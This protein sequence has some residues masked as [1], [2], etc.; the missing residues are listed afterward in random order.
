MSLPHARYLLHQP[1]T[2]LQGVA[3][4]IEITATE[5]LKLREK[6]NQ[7]VSDETGRAIEK[8]A[9]DMDRDFWMSAQEA[10]DYGLVTK[11]IEKRDELEKLS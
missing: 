2:H 4:D 7:I 11:I 10:L 8:V 9:S 1:S 6:A 5:I 3:A